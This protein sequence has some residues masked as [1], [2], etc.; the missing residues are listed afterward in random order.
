MLLLSVIWLVKSSAQPLSQHCPCFLEIQETILQT[1]TFIAT[2][3][4]GE[5]LLFYPSPQDIIRIY[6]QPPVPSFLWD[7]LDTGSL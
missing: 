5:N 3:G 1:Q 7:G 2:Q 4:S 6:Y